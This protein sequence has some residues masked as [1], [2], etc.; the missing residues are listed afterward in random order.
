MKELRRA[1]MK[2]NIMHQTF[3]RHVARVS[4]QKLYQIKCQQSEESQKD[5]TRRRDID[6][7]DKT[8]KKTNSRFTCFKYT[9]SSRE[10]VIEA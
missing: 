4:H 6:A 8:N 9:I 5:S 10:E 1:N 7:K 2:V 3:T